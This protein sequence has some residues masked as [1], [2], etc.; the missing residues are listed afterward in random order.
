M[1]LMRLY[2]SMFFRVQMP[3][4]DENGIKSLVKKIKT[5]KTKV[6]L[7]EFIVDELK[8]SQKDIDWDKVESFVN[9]MTENGIEEFPPI[10]VS[11]DMYIL[12]GHHRILA[13]RAVDPDYK[14]EAYQIDKN[15]I[16]AL[17]VFNECVEEIG[18]L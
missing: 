18:K 11:R 5:K 14:V 7:G 9:E 15:V 13:V 6:K 16:E 10:I 8:P 12:D 4:I 1:N 3:Q 17:T 2:E